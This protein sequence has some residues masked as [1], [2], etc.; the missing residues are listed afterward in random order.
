MDYLMIT[1]RN[2]SGDGL[3]GELAPV[4]FYRADGGT[5]AAAL[6][7]LS[8]WTKLTRNQFEQALK[9]IADTF[10]LLP[11]ALNTQQKHIALFVH[12]FNVSW[13]D[14]V[15]DY[16]EL[17]RN[18]M[19]ASNLGQLILFSWPSKGSVAGYLPDRA[20]ARDCAP[21]LADLFVDLND[22]LVQKQ[23]IAVKSD[24]PQKLCKAKISVLAHSMGCYVM[25]EA[26]V[27]ASKRLN[28][29][30]LVSLI[31]QCVLIA[32]DVDNDLFQR[33]K[34]VDSD[35]S[36]MA[37]LCYR[38]AALYTGLDSVL[39]ASAGLKHFGTRRLGRSGLADPLNVWDNVFEFDVTT[40]IDP[41]NGAHSAVFAA[42]PALAIV[43]NILR[44]IDRNYIAR[45]IAPFAATVTAAAV[46]A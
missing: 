34:P 43:A 44:G 23:R 32:G 8:S 1:N 27:A 9:A 30:Q 35:G 38:I 2:R 42:P 45:G 12:G 19:D 10:P 25:Q 14:A 36:L 11:D 24:D 4:A 29:P 6:K 28:D 39:G 16:L 33:D 5:D 40:Y 21:D 20:E 7:Q 26:L 37:N 22:Y 13:T 46:P 18:L 41:S 15:D 17:A 31:N 3:G